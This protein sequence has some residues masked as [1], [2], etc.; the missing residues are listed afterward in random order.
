MLGRTF[1]LHDNNYVVIDNIVCGFLHLQIR[2]VTKSKVD[3]SFEKSLREH[4]NYMIIMMLSLMI[5]SAV[6][7]PGAQ[8][9]RT[10]PWAAVCCPTLLTRAVRWLSASPMSTTS[11]SPSSPLVGCSYPYQWTLDIR[12]PLGQ[13]FWCPYKWESLQATSDN[14]EQLWQ[15]QQL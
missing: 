7:S 4:F 8:R 9:T 15:G 12:T 6:F 11:P 1:K 10:C 5:L 13:A 14:K 2:S 3:W